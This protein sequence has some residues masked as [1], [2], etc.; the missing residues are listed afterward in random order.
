MMFRRYSKAIAMVVLCFFTWTS[1]GVFSVA[2]AAQDAIKKGNFEKQQKK[3]E[4]PEERL[5]KVTDELQEVLADPKADV[6][7]KKLKLKAAMASIEAVDPEI[8]KEFAATEKKLKDAKLPD[9]ILQRHYRFVKRYEENRAELKGS[10]DRI[11]KAKSKAETE[12]E[13]GKAEKFLQKVKAWKKQTPLDP[14]NLPHRQPK[15]KKREPRLNKEEFEKDL[16]KD[17]TSWRDQ[18]RVM[19]ASAGSLAGL[20]VSSNVTAVTPITK[21]PAGPADLAETIEVQL[22]PEIR[23][24]ALE[25]EYKPLKIYEWVR[26]NV[27][28]V[29]TW[30]SIQ[31]ANHTLL[32]KQ[33]NAMDIASL[34]IA[35]LRAS[36]IHARYV[37]G[38][39]ELPIEKVMNWAGDFSDPTAALDFMSSGGIPMKGLVSGGK[40][41]KAQMEHVWVEAWID[42][43]PSRGAKHFKGK[44]DTWISLDASYKQYSYTNGID[45]K[46]AVPFDGQGFLDQLK[47]TATID[48][49]AGYVTG[50]DSLLTQQTM[51]DYQARVQS[52]IQQN[53]PNATVGDVLGKK[54]IVKQEFPYLLGTLPYRGAIRGAAFAEIPDSYRHKLSFNVRNDS[55]DLSAYDP[56]APPTADTAL[57]LT[58]SLPELAAKKITLSY[59]PATPQD[60]AVI[61]SYLPTP[62]ADGTPIQ[63]S[64]IP[65]SLPAYLIN[66]RPEL[67]VDGQVVAVGAPIG[68]GGTNIFT[69]TFSDPSYGSSQVTNYLDAGVYQAIGLNLG[70][71]SKDQLTTLKAKMEGATANLKNNDLTGLGKDDLVGDLLY[72]TALSYHAQLGAMNII[73]AKIMRVNA[74]TL[75]SETIF[76]TRLKVL[77]LWGIPRNVSLGGLNMDADYLMNVVKAK[78]GNNDTVKQYMLSSGM[79]SSA[80]EH[81]VP[82]QLFSTP[83]STIEGISTVKALKISNDLRVPIYTVNQANAAAVLPQLQLGQQ[84][85]DDI[86]NSINAGKIVTVSKSPVSFNG[87]SGCGYIVIDPETGAGAYMISGGLSGSDVKLDT[88]LASE[89]DYFSMFY[90]VR[91]EGLK[92]FACADMLKIFKAV[93]Y[94]VGI[95]AGIMQW[96]NDLDTISAA[97]NEYQWLMAYVLVTSIA[98][99]SVASMFLLAT[100]PLGILAGIG[101]TIVLNLIKTMALRQIFNVSRIKRRYLA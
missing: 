50:V 62:H 21:E 2:H 82:E 63:P 32:T 39:I 74:I 24:K 11:E 97:D 48:E 36:G 81:E 61:N 54:L 78:D 89:F 52:Y 60:E 93:I 96:I 76:A 79:T 77:C 26:N 68:L 6:D 37:T 59:S 44:E 94:K 29:P 69:M 90:G 10:V 101:L 86:Q 66:V 38:T 53:Y 7:A 98:I 57:Y 47:S 31:G 72:A 99:I 67:R 12:A 19:V 49:A 100:G 71:V 46:A 34:L 8:R 92:T 35:L 95:F 16:K 30:G 4:G 87:W 73:A 64:E 42:Y 23:A 56:D 43:I 13:I 20:L 18:K 55:V 88:R 65:S 9:E 85:K 3:A 91:G 5:S 84:V 75:P 1:G 14:N 40:I 45:I 27:E 80:L 22:T 15:V 25:L 83:E 41:V 33:G 70:R 51:Q 28:F 17:K 58:K